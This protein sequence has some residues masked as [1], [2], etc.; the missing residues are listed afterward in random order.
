MS[1]ESDAVGWVQPKLNLRR[2]GRRWRARRDGSRCRKR[3]PPGRAVSRWRRSPESAPPSVDRHPRF[4]AQFALRTAEQRDARL[5]DVAQS[6]LRILR[7]AATEGGGRDS[8][9]W[10]AGSVSHAGS[11]SIDGGCRFGDRGAG[12]RSDTGAH[13]EDDAAERPD[14]RALVDRV[15]ARL[16]RA[17][18]ARR[19]DDRP[20]LRRGGGVV[21]DVDDPLDAA[22]RSCA[23][24]ALA[25]PKSRTLTLPSGVILMFAGFRSRCTIPLSCAASSASASCR[26]M[27]VISRPADARAPAAD[28]ASDPRRTRARAPRRH[29]SPPTRRWRRRAD[30]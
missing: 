12:E 26:A 8:A 10:L 21:G 16:F 28:R 1:I 6:Q 24:K 13:L 25:R 7:Q 19:A 27:W 11:R 3:D 23:P 5:A 29:H 17:H 18:V 4:R 9:A 20:V 2:R 22:R 14:V 15:A 30:G